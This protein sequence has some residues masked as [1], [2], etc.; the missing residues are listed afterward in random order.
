M[1]KN[2]LN[3]LLR[4]FVTNRLSPNDV[5]RKIVSSI[6]ESLGKITGEGQLLQIGSYP[7]YTSIRP[8]HDLDVL[9]ILGDWDEHEHNPREALESIQA[10]I[11]EEFDPQGY[12]IRVSL[13]THSIT[14]VLLDK[15]NVEALSIDV[16]PAYVFGKNEFK[17]DMYKVPEI[18][19][20]AHRER[21]IIY[22][23][24]QASRQEM[25]WINS[26]PRGYIKV[27]TN[28]NS[29]NSDFRKAVKFVKGWKQSV[30][31]KDKTLML[32]SFHLEQIITMY[33]QQ[34]PRAD[35]F[36]GIFYF[37]CNLEK[38]ISAPQIP[39]RANDEVMIDAYVSDITSE[40]FEKICQ[41]IHCFMFKLES[42]DI[43][44]SVNSLIDACFYKR[45]LSEKFLYDFGI[46]TFIDRGVE[47]AIEGLL[48]N[49]DG[50]REYKYPL[51]AGHGRVDV[52]NH[53]K[54]RITKNTTHADYFKWKVKNDNDCKEPRGDIT[55]HQTK[56]DPESTK[57]YGEHFV[58]CYAIKDG[59]C[60]AKSR[61]NVII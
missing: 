55:D 59:I 27:A 36:D 37:Y 54:F 57:Y 32:K 20:R 38:F 13:Q 51:S 10:S 52:G 29:G 58:E 39:D 7:R 1:R 14:I 35:L 46:P 25:E 2:E 4:D 5:D 53:I 42:F 30:C 12:H 44:G 9:W 41:A 19:Q 15:N 40:Q 31:E 45:I 60:V 6:Y 8:I 47:L 61:Q 48:K 34:H 50:F 18:I 24:L 23:S 17:E 3:I 16:V 49:K 28:I 33:F 21:G 43:N 26:D 11:E 56:S 22:K